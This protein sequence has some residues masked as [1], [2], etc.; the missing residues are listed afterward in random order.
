MYEVIRNKLY[1]SSRELAHYQ[2]DAWR[3]ECPSAALR[4]DSI[5][6]GD[7]E[8]LYQKQKQSVHTSLPDLHTAH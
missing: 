5:I 2:S 4:Q 7:L 8:W 1:R 6:D 3:T